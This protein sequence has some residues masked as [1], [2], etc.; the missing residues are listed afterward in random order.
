M[1]TILTITV[2]AAAVVAAVINGMHNNSKLDADKTNFK[3]EGDSL[4]F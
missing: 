1:A 2:V 4:V 3:I